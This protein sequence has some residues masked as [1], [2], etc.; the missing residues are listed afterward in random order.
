MIPEKTV[1][2]LGAGASRPYLFPTAAELTELLLE[3][4]ENL[5]LL[6]NMGFSR[7]SENEV[8]GAPTYA[9]TDEMIPRK[10]RDWFRDRMYAHKIEQYELD[11]FQKRFRLSGCYS[12]DAFVADNPIWTKA[13]SLMVA[14]ILLRC[15][16]IER[17]EGDW[18]QYLLNELTKRGRDFPPETF[19]VVTFNYDRSLEMYLHQA[20]IHRYDLEPRHAWNMVKRI[21]IV[22][23]YGDLGP[24]FD[25]NGN[26]SLSYGIVGATKFAAENIKLANVRA[27]SEKVSEIHEMLKEASR[28]VILGFG[29]DELNLNALKMGVIG[30][31]VYA[32]RYSLPFPSMKD[33]ERHFARE[34]Y[35]TDTPVIWGQERETVLDFLRQSAAFA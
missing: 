1:L 30:K 21:K 11:E 33:A 18:Y 6:G 13:A 7:Y 5:V 27:G 31:P 24:L 17:L 19:S 3:R 34:N 25:D 14:C 23:V 22:H 10:Y 16:R 12:V 28:I 35:I 2:V 15:E 4:N 29:F 26:R 20:F 8:K 32:S 9:Q